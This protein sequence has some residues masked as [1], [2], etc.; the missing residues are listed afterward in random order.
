[1]GHSGSRSRCT[2][3]P[4]NGIGDSRPHESRNTTPA[5]HGVLCLKHTSST[6][7]HASV[8]LAAVP[9]CRRAFTSYHCPSECS[10]V[11]VVLSAQQD[12]SQTSTSGHYMAAAITSGL[13]ELKKSGIVP[14]GFPEARHP[15]VLSK[16]TCMCKPPVDFACF[17]ACASH[18]CT[19]QTRPDQPKLGFWCSIALILM[20]WD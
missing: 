2:V 3:E 10:A 5:A 20:P 12:V 14:D 15:K 17:W 11:A 13:H 8:K 16:L 19:S 18:A 9:P 7:Y 4:R 1:M 6:T